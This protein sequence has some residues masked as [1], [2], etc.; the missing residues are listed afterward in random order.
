MKRSFTILLLI[1]CLSTPVFAGHSQMGGRWCGCN[2]VQGVC[3][4]CG[5]NSPAT[6]LEI[7]TFDQNASGDARP[8]VETSIIRLAFLMWLKVKA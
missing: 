4:C 5:V 3:P 1:L 7:E 2:F 6:N 8:T